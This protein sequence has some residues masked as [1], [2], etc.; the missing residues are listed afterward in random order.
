MSKI[1]Q[2]V[3][4]G[5]VL[6]SATRTFN[7]ILSL[8]STLILAR[9]LMPSDFGL[10][11]FAVTILAIIM[12]LSGGSFSDAIVYFEKPES[13]HYH[14]VWTLNAL[15]ALFAAVLSCAIS[16]LISFFYEDKRLMYTIIVLSIG[17]IVTGFENPK[18][19]RATKDLVFWQQVTIQLVQRI[20]SFLLAITIAFYFQSY[21]ALIIGTISGQICGI[22]VS[23]VVAPYVPKFCLKHKIEIIRFAGWLNLSHAINALNW[24]FDNLL[25]GTFLGKTELGYYTVGNNLAIIPSR[26]TIA[27]LTSTLYPAFSNLV[28]EPERLARAYQKAQSMVMAIALPAGVGVALV[29]EPLVVLTMGEK[30]LPSVFL[31]QVLSS[32]FALQTM[33]S[34]AQP[35]AMAAGKTRLLFVRDFQSFIGRIP[36]VFFG[37]YL[38]GLSGIVYARA[39]FG[40]ASILLNILIVR[41]ITNLGIFDQL[42]PAFRPLVS[43]FL[44]VIAVHGIE[45][46]IFYLNSP[47][48]PLGRLII[49]TT[50]GAFIY[51]LTMTLLWLAMGR[52]NGPEGTIKR[53]ILQLIIRI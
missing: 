41:R 33:G 28:N 12:A 51:V 32:V 18:A 39:L 3:F 2:K 42:S 9:L 4:K 21:W 15:K 25:I 48:G 7:N 5:A 8:I 38:G 6:M 17:T 36:T 19:I 49:S 45:W 30:W 46:L 53:S 14:T 47:I 34:L 44:M 35:L 10:V 13:T 23:Y 20:V 16:W 11:A 50:V 1:Q 22:L 40:I 52:P 31:I 27:P 24:N 29:A 43:V 26:E 37:M